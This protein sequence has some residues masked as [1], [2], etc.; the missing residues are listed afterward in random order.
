MRVLLF[1][2]TRNGGT[3]IMWTY[4]PAGATA[5]ARFTN[6]TPPAGNLNLQLARTPDGRVWAGYD[7]TSGPNS[8][9]PVLRELDIDLGTKTVVFTGA[10][11]P[12]SPAT[13]ISDLTAPA[14]RPQV[15]VAKRVF[16]GPTAHGDGTFSATFEMVIEALGDF[17]LWDLQVSD[18]L[19]TEFGT[20]VTDTPDAPGEYAVT[21]APAITAENPGGAP[22]NSDLTANP[23][24]DG[25]TDQDLLVLTFGRLGRGRCDRHSQVHHQVLSGHWQDH[26]PKPGGGGR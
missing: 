22:P 12:L 10:E 9:S 19:T 26:L 11:I 24:F 13:S 3:L 6:L 18:D 17:P 15:G 7:A 25:D 1:G 2:A 16:S 5:S 20:L 21:S 8:G 14:C 23:D 4:D